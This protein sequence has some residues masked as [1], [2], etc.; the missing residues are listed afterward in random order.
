M[1]KIITLLPPAVLEQIQR[2]HEGQ[3]P[4]HDWAHI[5]RVVR[6]A[7][8][9]SQEEGADATVVLA[10]A[11]LHDIVNVPKDHPERHRASELA[12]DKAVELLRETTFPQD[13]LAAVHTAI[14]EHSFSR[15]LKPSTL[16]AAVVQDADRLDALGAIGV[17]RCAA[18]NTAMGTPFY[19]PADPLARGRELDDRRWMVD[20]YFLKLLRL[21][22]T[23]A[24]ATGKRIGHERAEFMRAFLAQLEGEVSPSNSLR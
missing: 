13:K 17:L 1:P 8:E 2:Y 23:M 18:V 4:G 24:T 5:Q 14:V 22:D 11:H 12:A 9:I 6:T 21:P 16:E 10:A 15:G 3:D 20:H 7:I 19:D